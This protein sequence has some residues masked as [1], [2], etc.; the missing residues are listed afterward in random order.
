MNT[1]KRPF[2]VWFALV[3][4]A[5]GAL[6]T[7]VVLYERSTDLAGFDHNALVFMLNLG[8][9][10]L[11]VVTFDAIQRRSQR[12]KGLAIVCLSLLGGIAIYNAVLLFQ[13][14]R[15]VPHENDLMFAKVMILSRIS[16][17][18]LL[19]IFFGFSGTVNQYFKQRNEPISE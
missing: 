11:L 3:Y 15:S 14:F 4:L 6:T 2:L 17:S 18:F 7:L 9:C 19:A 1:A 16:I 10:F 13:W 12:G 5:A 8:M